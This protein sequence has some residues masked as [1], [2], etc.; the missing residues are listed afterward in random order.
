MSDESPY[1][2]AKRKRAGY[3]DLK[4]DTRTRDSKHG[5]CCRFWGPVSVAEEELVERLI[6]TLVSQRPSW[7]A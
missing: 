6:K 4:L 5:H 3:V 1:K 2:A 7:K